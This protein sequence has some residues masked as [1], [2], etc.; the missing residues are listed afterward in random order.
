[1]SNEKKIGKITSV[2]FGHCGY[3]DAMIGISF[4]LGSNSW[5]VGT[6]MSYWDS[7]CKLGA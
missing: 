5:G 7:R 4:T 2:S 3:Q 6:D 1:M